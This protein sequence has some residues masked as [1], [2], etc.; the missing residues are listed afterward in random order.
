[1][2]RLANGEIGIPVIITVYTGKPADYAGNAI[3]K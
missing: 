3:K 1:M 2:G